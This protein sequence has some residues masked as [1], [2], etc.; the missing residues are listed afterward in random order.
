VV[1]LRQYSCSYMKGLRKTLKTPSEKAICGQIFEPV[2]S[3]SRIRSD[4]ARQPHSVHGS[5]YVITS[6]A[7]LSWICLQTGV[8]RHVSFSE[9]AARKL[10]LTLIS[11]SPPCQ[12]NI[13]AVVSCYILDLTFHKKINIQTVGLS[14]LALQTNFI[15]C[16]GRLNINEIIR[17]HNSWMSS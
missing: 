11:K 6:V 13:A 17:A 14:E 1:Y 10:R 15:V 5:F 2:T 3:Q 16:V 9:C 12:G 8:A 4:I 7:C